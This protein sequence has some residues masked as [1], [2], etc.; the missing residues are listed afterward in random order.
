MARAICKRHTLPKRSKQVSYR[1]FLSMQQDRAIAQW[2]Q[3]ALFAR[4]TASRVWAD[5]PYADAAPPR[6]PRAPEGGVAPPTLAAVLV[7]LR[8]DPRE[9]GDGVGPLFRFLMAYSSYP[10]DLDFML[11]VLRFHQQFSGGGGVN[12]D[13]MVAAALAIYNTYLVPVRYADAVPP[14]PCPQFLR[15]PLVAAAATVVGTP[16]GASSGTPSPSS[17]SSSPNLSTINSTGGGG[18][19]G[20][21]SPDPAAEGPLVVL[22]HT[23]ANEVRSVLWSSARTKVHAE[24]FRRA[25]AFVY[26]RAQDTWFR[27]LCASRC[28]ADREYDT[29]TRDAAAVAAYLGDAAV[30]ADVLRAALR[31]V[32]Y[33][34]IV[35]DPGLYTRFAAFQDLSLIHI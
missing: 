24:V 10:R 31:A 19:S 26:Q 29:D 30:V 14:S 33:D 16:V 13:E 8:D 18:G 27:E 2:A 21:S 32:L 1:L 35:A 4:W 6:Q 28:W 3:H 23:L 9:C 20:S 15:N 12:K 7:S 22:D 11:A 25:G 17:S 34:D 5:V